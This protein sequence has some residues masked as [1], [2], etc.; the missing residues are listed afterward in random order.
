MSYQ[1][2]LILLPAADTPI[3][4]TE[5][6]RS[7]SDEEK[8]APPQIRSYYIIHFIMGGVLQISENK[9]PK[10]NAILLSRGL[11]HSF[12]LRAPFDHFW[13]GFDGIGARKLL[14]AFAI[15]TDR[16]AILPLT[17]HESL[18]HSL[19][20]GIARIAKSRSS[21]EA[22]ALLLS[23]LPSL[24]TCEKHATPSHAQRAKA[25]I[26]HNFGHPLS[27]EDVAAAVN[28]TEKHLCRLFKR[29]LSVT[30]KDYLT[31]R[32]MTVARE[33]VTTTDI[34][35]SE[36]P[37]SVGVPAPL[38]FSSAYKHYFGISPSADRDAEA[39]KQ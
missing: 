34:L 1:R 21:T 38:A 33:L 3:Y 5:L 2:D 19:A 17:D 22:L 9:A 23:L 16:H 31:E 27:M 29:E 37:T 26:D 4:V 10:G 7:R 36:I 11:I 15:P 32:R 13:I 8:I 30:P 14:E 18:S 24:G 25:F 35:I 39:K 20:D 6:G 28:V 12:T